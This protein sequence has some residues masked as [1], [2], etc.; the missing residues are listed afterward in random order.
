MAKLPKVYLLVGI[1][2]SGKSTFSKSLKAV[3]EVTIVSSDTVRTLHPDWDEPKI[4][5][6]VYRLVAE[7]LSKG[8]DVVFDATNPTPRVRKRFFD[9]MEPY[10]VKFECSA[11]YFPTPYRECR[12][13]IRKRNKMKDERFFPIRK[14]KGFAKTITCPTVEEGFK[15]VVVMDNK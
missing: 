8:I 11:Y 13:R 12:R 5:P 9:N 4:F 2:G 7:S 6:E 15:E 14:L 1:P 10:K 3:Q